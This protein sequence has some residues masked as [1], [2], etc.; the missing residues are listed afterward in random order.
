MDRNIIGTWYNELGSV[1][2][3]SQ[4]SDGQFSGHYYTRVGN[5]QLYTYDL[6]GRYDADPNGRTLG[7][8]VAWYNALN[9]SSGSTTTWSG[10]Y[11][12][13]SEPRILTTWLLTVQTDPDDN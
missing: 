4:A 10:Q 3:I 5:A 8:T 13:D 9:G 11:Q 2:E 6:I 1:M 7:W 12:V